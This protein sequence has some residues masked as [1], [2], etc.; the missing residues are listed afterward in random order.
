MSFRG[1]FPKGVALPDPTGFTA[2]AELFP[3]GPH[4]GEEGG[5]GRLVLKLAWWTSRKLGNLTID[6]CSEPVRSKVS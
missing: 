2:H 3:R 6:Q 5:R 4:L 1:R